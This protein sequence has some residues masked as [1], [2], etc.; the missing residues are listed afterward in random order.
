MLGSMARKLRALGFDASYFS[1]GEDS[2]MVRVAKSEGRIILTADADF[3]RVARSRGIPAVLVV[4]ETDAERL[5]SLARGAKAD[6]L[7]LTRGSP[8][9][10]LCGSELR[11]LGRKEA[12]HEVPP[13]VHARHR[14]FSKCRSCGKAYWKGSHWKKL[15]SLARL[16]ETKSDAALSQ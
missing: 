12:E 16:L 11:T 8:R 10:S 3:A 14:D 9:C 1:H 2:V 15:R 7:P 6:G 13:T 5:S 4:G